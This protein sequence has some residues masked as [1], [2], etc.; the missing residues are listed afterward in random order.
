MRE[1]YNQSLRSIGKWGREG[2]HYVRE[3]DTR[4]RLTERKGT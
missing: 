2:G 1:S 3:P 4:H